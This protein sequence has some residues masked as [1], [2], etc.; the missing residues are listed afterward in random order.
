MNHVMIVLRAMKI[1]C[2]TREGFKG[3]LHI[4]LVIDD[5]TTSMFDPDE[6]IA[7]AGMFVLKSE[8]LHN[9]DFDEFV[10]VWYTIPAMEVGA[11]L[12]RGWNSRHTDEDVSENRR[13]LL[14]PKWSAKVW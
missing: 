3:Y 12:V 8:I 13:L 1:L 11:C 5:L 4:P 9:V 6:G 7:A 10:W 14:T 2:S